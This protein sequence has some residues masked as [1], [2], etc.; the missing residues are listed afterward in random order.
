MFKTILNKL[1]GTTP[2]PT[3][4]EVTPP[5][6]ETVNAQPVQKQEPKKP[7]AAIQAPKKAPAKP[8]AKTKATKKK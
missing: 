8:A 5:K 2:A 7:A 4:V 6:V 3:P 1:F